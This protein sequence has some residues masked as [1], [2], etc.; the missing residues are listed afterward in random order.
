LAMHSLRKCLYLAVLPILLPVLASRLVAQA[1]SSPRLAD[2][3]GTY[4]DA[5]GHTLEIA[6][7]DGLFSFT[8]PGSIASPPP[9]VK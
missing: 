4:V 1:I 7:G 2:Y 3:V 5:P 6:D 9:P 8:P